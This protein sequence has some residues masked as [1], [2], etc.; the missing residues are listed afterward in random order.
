MSLLD[1]QIG[2]LN[3]LFSIKPDRGEA[4]SIRLVEEETGQV[5]KRSI[6]NTI[7]CDVIGTFQNI[8]GD[9]D[10]LEKGMIS[11]PMS[12]HSDISKLEEYI[13]EKYSY[14][15]NIISKSDEKS[16]TFYDYLVA[17]IE[18]GD[19]E[20][21]KAT[22]YLL[23]TFLCHYSKE[24]IDKID[25][26]KIRD[27]LL[28]DSDE[29]ILEMISSEHFPNFLEDNDETLVHS[30]AF[31]LKDNFLHGIL[32]YYNSI[33]FCVKLGSY[34]DIFQDF[35][36]YVHPQLTSNNP[37]D[38]FKKENL[39]INRKVNIFSQSIKNEFKNQ[40]DKYYKINYQ[41]LSEKINKHQ[42]KE[43]NKKMTSE[44]RDISSFCELLD[45]W[46]AHKAL[47]YWILSNQEKEGDLIYHFYLQNI[48]VSRSY[49]K[50][51]I[52]NPFDE[53]M[54]F[55]CQ[56]LSQYCFNNKINN[57]ENVISIVDNIIYQSLIEKVIRNTVFVG[58]SFANNFEMIRITSIKG[59]GEVDFFVVEKGLV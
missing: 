1:S 25:L 16:K 5:Y 6:D 53:F 33:T 17:R 42:T 8:I 21:F 36:V 40:T 13:R 22:L 49:P 48:I 7:I 35:V 58:Y 15:I 47:I 18:F 28:T 4:K 39:S 50:I 57:N 54:N 59:I 10:P 51:Y 46:H 45:F 19:K 3:N 9:S 55:V 29:E 27:I 44:L 26:N 30:F 41:R 52:R 32:S 38:N 11:L 14:G 43:I 56:K 2:V 20:F 12:C 23:L 31:V 34:N 37:N 24:T